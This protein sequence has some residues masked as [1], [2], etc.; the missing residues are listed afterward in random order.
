MG[1]NSGK[2]EEKLEAVLVRMESLAHE[3]TTLGKHL[4]TTRRV[5]TRY[6]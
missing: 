1:E 6:D 2:L 5:W 3:I 4:E